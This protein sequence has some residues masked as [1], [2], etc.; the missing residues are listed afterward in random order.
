MS[1]VQ[2]IYYNQLLF[3]KKKKNCSC[4]YPAYGTCSFSHH[5]RM[6]I[7]NSSK[8]YYNWGRGE[9]NITFLINLFFNK[10]NIRIIYGSSALHLMKIIVWYLVVVATLHFLVSC[11]SSN[12]SKHALLFKV[13]AK[14]L[15]LQHVIDDVVG[16]ICKRAELGVHYGVIL[17]PEGLIEFIPEVNCCLRKYLYTIEINCHFP[18]MHAGATTHC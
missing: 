10:E 2:K 9:T 3:S 4:S 8:Y 14:K 6:C 11:F 15:C 12:K 13:A 1:F 5:L 16:I 18:S 17:L 7:A